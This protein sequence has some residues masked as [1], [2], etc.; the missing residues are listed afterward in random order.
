M[1]D[2]TDYPFV[3][4]STELHVHNRLHPMHAHTHRTWPNIHGH[5]GE[6][7]RDDVRVVRIDPDGSTWPPMTWEQIDAIKPLADEPGQEAF[8]RREPAAT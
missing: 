2:V 5:G 6:P 8:Q 3:Q 7:V 4:Y 1:A